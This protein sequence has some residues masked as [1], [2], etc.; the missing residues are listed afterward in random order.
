MTT[1]KNNTVKNDT[2]NNNTVDGLSWKQA[3]ALVKWGASSNG[4]KLNLPEIKV[5]KADLA[6][7]KKIVNGWKTPVADA[8]PGVAHWVS[9]AKTLTDLGMTKKSAGMILDGK[10]KPETMIKRCGLPAEVLS[11]KF[12]K[13]TVKEPTF[14]PA[15]VAVPVAQPAAGMA[16]FAQESVSPT[17]ATGSDAKAKIKRLIAAG[18][19]VD[20]ALAMVGL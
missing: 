5:S 12:A 11:L 19:S 14:K 8:I 16:F 4:L 6:S 15:P 18:F 9:V 1:A 20:E 10:L 17:G 3:K 2:V 7:A 13:P